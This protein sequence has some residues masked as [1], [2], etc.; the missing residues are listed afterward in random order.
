[1]PAAWPALC[2]LAALLV[3]LLLIIR[4][5]WQPFLALLVVSLGLGLAAGM[6]PLRVLEAIG[7]GIGGIL[8]EVA[9][10]LVLG[11]VL[12]RML[13]ASRAAE[14]IARRLIELFGVER[15]SLAILAAGYLIGIP[16]LFNVGFLLLAPLAWQLQRETGRSL[17]WYL[18]PLGLSLA[19]TH[20]LIPP[21]PG[22]V[23]AVNNMN[24]DMVQTMLFG[25]LMSIPVA[26]VGWLGPGRWWARREFI[27][28]PDMPA[29]RNTVGDGKDPD[30]QLPRFGVCL[31]IVTLPLW[32]SL[33][34][35]G[36]KLL[37]DLSRLPAWFDDHHLGEWLQFLG[38]PT[39][40][41]LIPTGLAFVLLGW[42]QGL[43][44][45]RLN[46]IAGDGLNDVGAMALLFGAA[47]AFKQVIQD[48]G[49]GGWL[50]GQLLD[51]PVS[52]VATCFLVA[53]A[54]RLALGSATAAILTA[55]ALLAGFSTNLPERST[56]LV[57][58]VANG[59]TIFTQP[60]DSGFWLVKEFGH[61]SVRQ[62]LVR[63]NLCRVTLAL[64][65]GLI[66]LVW[67]QMHYY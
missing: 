5:Q 55:S 50:A 56:L 1:M 8:K 12:G 28:P 15:A 16:M 25:A 26:L 10:L 22:I 4:F 30:R 24:A 32:L 34:G 17:L 7:N 38:H 42:R 21:H 49:A 2:T 52:P 63:Y 67:E 23:G 47:G 19:T 54:M 58:A 53:A 65:G 29:S 13:E 3:L 9:I 39:M 66:L 14:V 43:D 41:M 31:L 36:A 18:L 27:T 20:S 44:R 48:S 59:V 35:F 64:T 46:K 45:Q 40:A 57:L 60:A 62:V 37:S 6:P 51:L 11:A 61:L 33:L